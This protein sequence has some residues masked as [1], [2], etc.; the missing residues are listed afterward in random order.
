MSGRIID[1]PVE[2]ILKKIGLDGHPRDAAI[3]KK[4][5]QEIVHPGEV[6]ESPHLADEDPLKISAQL[7]MDEFE[8]VTNGMV[9]REAPAESVCPANED[10]FGPWRTLTDA[11]A[12]FY[13]GDIAGM[14]KLA[15]SIPVDTTASALR[16]VFKILGGRPA[17]P[18][19]EDHFAEIVRARGKELVDGLGTLD[20]A[21]AYP[22]LLRREILRYLP[23]IARESQEGA[24]R[25]Y[26]WAMEVLCEDEPIN[27]SDELTSL[28]P[29]SGEASRICALASMNYDVDRALLA[30]LRSLDAVL[31]SG[32]IESLET[33]VRLKIAG[34]IAEMAEQQR[35]LTQ[36]VGSR[37]CEILKGSYHLLKKLLPGI[38]PVPEDSKNLCYWLNESG[39]GGENYLNVKKSI[40]TRVKDRQHGTT[41]RELLLFDEA[42]L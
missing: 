22:N 26:Y 11:I 30:W 2:K 9:R 13:S 18:D 31:K 17:V 20:E 24:K 40:R 27:E 3:M 41:S 6:A 23:R 29:G 28:I 19:T 39:T 32:V 42:A 14:K 38:K 15:D 21:S 33:E 37:A 4:L 25:L 36:D 16:D 35:L 12:A 10:P 8:A 7:V 1:S 5:A 34:E